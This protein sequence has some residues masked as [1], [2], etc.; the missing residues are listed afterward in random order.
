MMN[1]GDASEIAGEI[2]LSQMRKPIFLVTKVVKDTL[3]ERREMSQAQ[4][5]IPG[6]YISDR[7]DQ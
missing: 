6:E 3:N 4:L 2:E 7:L 5:V 1:Q